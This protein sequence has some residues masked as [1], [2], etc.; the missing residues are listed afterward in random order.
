VIGEHN[1]YTRLTDPVVHRRTLDLDERSRI[2]TIQDDIVANGTHEIAVHFHL[3]ED[4]LVSAERPNRYKI[5][6]GG[7]T[8][9][10]EMDAHL[11]VDVVKGGDEPIGGWTSRG[12][13]RKVPSTTLIARGRCP[14]NRSYVSR[15]EIGPAP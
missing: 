1:G 6:V 8:V 11:G 10:L 13:H 7:G 4:A 9:A 14:G 3:A 12:Y 2:L 15:I 5:E